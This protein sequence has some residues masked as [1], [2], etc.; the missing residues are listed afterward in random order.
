MY[1]YCITRY[2]YNSCN[3]LRFSLL[4]PSVM[5]IFS[6]NS[7]CAHRCINFCCNTNPDYDNEI[8]EFYEGYKQDTAN[9]TILLPQ[10][11]VCP[12]REWQ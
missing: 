5:Q 11:C 3:E 10:C 2:C 8:A 12:F 7:E 6:H 4:A 1:H 9:D